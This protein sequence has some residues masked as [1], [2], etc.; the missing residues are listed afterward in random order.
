MV[1]QDACEP[2][3]NEIVTLSQNYGQGDEPYIEASYSPA[4]G[5]AKNWSGPNTT[6]Q[7]HF[8]IWLHYVKCLYELIMSNIVKKPK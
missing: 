3:N 6:L 1:C 2:G 7:S 5:Y 4:M 8:H